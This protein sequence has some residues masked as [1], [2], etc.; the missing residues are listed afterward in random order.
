ML[1][2]WISSI[3]KFLIL[4]H[5]HFCVQWLAISFV[6]FRFDLFRFVLFRFVSICFV[7]FRFDLFRFVSICFVSFR[8]VSVSFRTLH[9]PYIVPFLI[10]YCLLLIQTLMITWVRCIPFNLRLMARRRATLLSIGRDSHLHASLFHKR[11]ALNFHI[12]NFPVLSN[13]IPSLSTYGG[14]I[15]QLKRYTRSCFTCECFY[16]QISEDHVTFK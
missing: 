10:T 5:T 7:S 15:S 11:D 3:R 12:K 2:K 16:S 13:T 9:G 14:F 8:F 1:K 4:E 6:S